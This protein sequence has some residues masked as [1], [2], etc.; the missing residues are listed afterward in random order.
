MNEPKKSLLGRL[1]DSIRWTG[2][3]KRVA[4]HCADGEARRERKYRP[5]RWLPLIPILFACAFV[6]IAVYLPQAPWQFACLAAIVPSM[7]PQMIR[8]PLAKQAIEDDEREA[9]LRKDAF[10]FC[11]A[12]LA[13]LNVVL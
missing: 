3:P 8:G 5:R 12:L 4:E 10:Y 1:D 6:L 13:I 7:L 11:F 2:M 9:A